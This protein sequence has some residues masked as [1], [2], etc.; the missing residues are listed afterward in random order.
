[1]GAALAVSMLGAAAAPA[2]A[3]DA[4]YVYVNE[5]AAAD[6][7]KDL[8]LVGGGNLNG[9]PHM[10]YSEEKQ[11]M[12]FESVSSNSG[13]LLPPYV[14]MNNFVMEADFAYENG[15]NIFYG[16]IFNYRDNQNFTDIRYNPINGNVTMDNAISEIMKGRNAENGNG[17]SVTAAEG[18][19][20]HLKLIVNNGRMEFFV[21]DELC[22]TYYSNTE[23]PSG[24]HTQSRDFTEGGRLGLFFKG[25]AYMTVKNLKVRTVDKQYDTAYY[26]NSWNDNKYERSSDF[27]NMRELSNA[28]KT[29]SLNDGNW[30]ELSYYGDNWNNVGIYKDDIKLTGDYTIDMNFSFK[31][32]RNASR[33]I[34]FAIGGTK[35]KTTGNFRYILAAVKPDGGM[36]IQ[37]KEVSDSS[38]STI[39]S[40]EGS[41]ANTIPENKK[42]VSDPPQDTEQNPGTYLVS[43]MPQNFNHNG[44]EYPDNY[45][46]TSRRHN[47]HLEVKDGNV[48][49][50]FEGTTITLDPEVGTDG[51]FGIRSAGMDAN[52]YSLR[53]APYTGEPVVYP[54]PENILDVA[55]VTTSAGAELGDPAASY[56]TT[57]TLN[58][59]PATCTW[60]VT[61]DQTDK[62]VTEE[63]TV[64]EGASIEGEVAFGLVVTIPQGKQLDS[65]HV[66]ALID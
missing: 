34:G 8:E 54:E 14:N 62:I 1:M 47:L 51:L 3:A 5:L 22:Y 29:G 13:F 56:L 39:K 64:G 16:M 18:K 41:C 20:T 15:S 9:T 44:N 17:A 46:V 6:S 30:G 7:L 65:L 24:T 11:S 57:A 45:D 27:K 21:N 53:V 25:D 58:N 50:T 60:Y 48:S 26:S 4:Q 59:A 66:N 55:R 2:L 32:P 40:A 35:N 61:A 28:W 63:C 49:M 43:Y 10:E 42:N 33:F 23:N 52:I 37:E 31:Y 38:E 12:Y 36:F 19:E